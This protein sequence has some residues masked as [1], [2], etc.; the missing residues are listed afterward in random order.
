M[1]QFVLTGGVVA[2]VLLLILIAACQSEQETSVTLPTRAA[3]V[4]FTPSLSPSPSLIPSEVWTDTPTP[5]PTLTPSLSPTIAPS[6]TQIALPF[7]TATAS[8]QPTSIQGVV[9]SEV[10]AY[11]RRGPGTDYEIVGEILSGQTF[12]IMAYMD[13]SIGDTWYLVRLE[14]GTQ[15]WISDMVADLIQAEKN[16]IALAITQPPTATQALPTVELPTQVPTLPAGANAQVTGDLGV[17]LRAGPSY[18]D[19]ILQVLDKGAPLTLIGRNQAATWYETVTSGSIGFVG[20]VNAGFVT[21]LIDARQLAVTWV[22]PVA[23]AGLQCGVNI[24]PKDG[25]GGLPIPQALTQADWVRFPFTASLRYFP[26]VNAAFAYFDPIINAYHAAGVRVILVLTHETYGELAG[27][28]WLAMTSQDWRNFTASY[29]GVAEQIARHYGDRV[30]AYEIWNEGDTQRGDEAGVAIPPADYAYLLSQTS[31]AIRRAAPSAQVVLG[32][33]LDASGFYL[34]GVEKALN[35]KLPVDAIAIHPYGRGAPNTPSVF[36][37]F[38]NI[39]EVIEAYAGIAPTTP[40]WITEIGALGA[41]RPQEAA[42]YLGS[43]VEYLKTAYPDRVALVAWYGWSDA[44]HASRTPNGLVGVNGQ[45]TNPLY[46]TFF[47][48]CGS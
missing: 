17:N 31:S 15:A 26:N 2:W 8:L 10:G 24:H 44:M 36:A 9:V 35:G 14:D 41:Y 23:S 28:D 47:G 39:G 7:P 16:E 18:N 45:P 37:S 29:T 22:G 34:R 12:S 40:L 3:L 48:F 19:E 13:S 5:F 21:P 20:W 25:Q 43:L 46:Q 33:L 4:S 38:G 42:L 32:G 27:W 30:A 6:N 1:R 11:L